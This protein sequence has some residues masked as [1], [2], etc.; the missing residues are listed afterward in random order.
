MQIAVFDVCDTIYRVNTTFGFLDYYF[1]NNKKYIF[2]RKITKLF[3]V[4]VFNY[5]VYT[6]WLKK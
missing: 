1:G 4:R 3:P 5:F 2:F 6:I